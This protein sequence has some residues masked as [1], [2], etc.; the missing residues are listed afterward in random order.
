VSVDRSAAWSD[1]WHEHSV[2][3]AR[4][5]SFAALGQLFD[6]YR[7]YLLRIAAQ[8]LP[9]DLRGKIGA[10][11]VVQETFLQATQDFPRFVGHTEAELKAWLRRILL[12]NVLDAHKRFT[13]QKRAAELEVPIDVAP[14]AGAIVCPQPRPSSLAYSAEMRVA[15]ERGMARLPE[16]YR[17]VIELRT[18][19][20][21]S[22]EEVG[23]VLSRSAEAARRLWSRAIQRLMR[24]LDE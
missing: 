23:R 4:A 24:E 14:H 12:N 7:D 10:S 21:M 11:D 8:E 20:E 13:T 19:E 17:R 3:A 1:V 16:D 9:A 18:F 2:A 15:I 5:G 22:F 6:H